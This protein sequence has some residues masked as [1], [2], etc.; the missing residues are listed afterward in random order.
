MSSLAYTKEEQS[1]ISGEVT[2]GIDSTFGVDGLENVSRLIPQVIDLFK[3]NKYK[4]YEKEKNSEQKNNGNKGNNQNNNNNNSGNGNQ[5]PNKL[6]AYIPKYNPTVRDLEL[7]AKYL[8][9]NVE[10]RKKLS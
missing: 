2:F 8:S 3:S 5:P 4:D 9:K 10:L 7:A 6:D 1:K